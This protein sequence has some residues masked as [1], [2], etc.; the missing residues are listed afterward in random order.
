MFI[1]EDQHRQTLMI[2]VERLYRHL[3]RTRKRQALNIEAR[4]FRWV[5]CKQPFNRRAV[6]ADKAFARILRIGKAWFEE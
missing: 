6:R 2:R 3:A 5:A 4:G 1:T